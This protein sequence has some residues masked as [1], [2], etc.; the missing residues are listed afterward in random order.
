MPL[1]AFLNILVVEFLILTSSN[2]LGPYGENL[3]AGYGSVS[4]SIDAWYNEINQYSFSNGGF[5]VCPH[6]FYGFN[7]SPPPV[8]LLK[9]FGKDLRNSAAPG[10]HVT[11]PAHQANI[12]CVNTLPLE[13]SLVFY[14]L[15]YS[16][17]PGQFQQ[18]VLPEA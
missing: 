4:A 7:I 12:L 9:S 10:S 2:F 3:A 6:Y 14:L 5:S 17:I 8:T 1:A 15:D 11:Q 13:T 16:L 18:N